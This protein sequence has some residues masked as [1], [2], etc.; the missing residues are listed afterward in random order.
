ME[1]FLPKQL[2][3][4]WGVVAAAAAGVASGIAA[5][6]QND[7][8]RTSW[9]RNRPPQKKLNLSTPKQWI[10]MMKKSI[11]YDGHMTGVEDLELENP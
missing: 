10:C 2:V 5:K 1:I 7:W 9:Y 4:A 3:S 6:E 11:T 8:G